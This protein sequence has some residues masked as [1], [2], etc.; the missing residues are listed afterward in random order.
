MQV[1]K[2]QYYL[3]FPIS[4]QAFQIMFQTS[5]KS[6][7][8]LFHIPFFILNDLYGGLERFTGLGMFSGEKGGGGL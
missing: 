2:I 3:I 4:F 7:T 8:K 1:T 6:N 5:T